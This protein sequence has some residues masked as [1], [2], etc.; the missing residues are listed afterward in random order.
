MSAETMLPFIIG[1][2]VLGLLG[3]FAAFGITLGHA[4]H[5]VWLF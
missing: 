5:L 1:F 3:L 4:A 2:D